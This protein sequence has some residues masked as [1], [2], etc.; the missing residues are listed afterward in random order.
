MV[1]TRTEVSDAY[2]QFH[3]AYCLVRSTSAQHVCLTAAEQSCLQLL[4]RVT[5]ACM[6]THHLKVI[7]VVVYL[8]VIDFICKETSFNGVQRSS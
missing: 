2:Q 7:F 6:G 4:L 5:S 1:S 8:R 3:I